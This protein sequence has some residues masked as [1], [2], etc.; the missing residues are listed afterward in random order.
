MNV[1]QLLDDLPGLSPIPD[2]PRTDAG[3]NDQGESNEEENG[4]GVR[5]FLASFFAG[6][7][8]DLFQ[9]VIAFAIGTGVGALVCQYYGLPLALSTRGG[10]PVLTSYS[11][12]A[13]Q[14]RLT[15]HPGNNNRVRMVKPVSLIYERRKMAR[16]TWCFHSPARRYSQ[17]TAAENGHS[18]AVW[19]CRHD[20]RF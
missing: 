10:V 18:M 2:L 16:R 6:R 14:K 12:F 20:W 13:G 1:R 17:R 9:F 7:A 3:M 15:V 11:R 5:T 4:R 8:R 19:P